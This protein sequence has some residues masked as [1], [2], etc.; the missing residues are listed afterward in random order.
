MDPA[1]DL[2][3]NGRCLTGG[4]LGRRL[5]GLAL[6]ALVAGIAAAFFRGEAARADPVQHVWVHYDYMAGYDSTDGRY[7]SFE[8]DPAAIRLVVDAFRR[9]GV[10]LHIGPSHN[11]IP[12][13]EVIIPDFIPLQASFFSPSCTGPDA[14]RYST[15]K[16]RYFHPPSDHPWHYMIFADSAFTPEDGTLLANCGLIT[17][18][19][20]TNPTPGAT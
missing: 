11:A 4:R 7:V 6:F 10:I 8:P 17:A 16:A 14:V 19:P 20:P 9:H 15:L 18:N 5:F 3:T 12:W 2:G 13:H 1:E